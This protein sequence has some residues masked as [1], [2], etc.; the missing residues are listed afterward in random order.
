MAEIPDDV[1]DRIRILTD[2]GNAWMEDEDYDGA[3]E[4]FEEALTL[5]P[6]PWTDWEAATWI[7]T[8]IGDAYFLS[9]GYQEAWEAFN[10]AV[11]CP[12]GKENPFVQLRLGQSEFELGNMDLAAKHL[13]LAHGLDGE[14]VFEDEDP[15][16]LE[17]AKRGLAKPA[18]DAPPSKPWWKL[19]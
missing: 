8:A 16:Y 6:D 10:D 2:Q 5:V 11:D 19:W 17:L 4:Q 12:G 14:R 15:K 3:L 18:Q 13:G 9:G 1:M 7:L